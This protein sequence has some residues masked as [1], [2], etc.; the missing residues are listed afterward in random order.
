M[1]TAITALER[2]KD[3]PALPPEF[4]GATPAAAPEKPAPV[5]APATPAAEAAPATEPTLIVN[6]AA[7]GELIGEFINESQEHLANIENGV[8]VLEDDPTNADTLNTIFR[9]FHTFKGGSGFLN[10]LPIQALAHELEFLLDAARQ[11][12]LTLSSP[13][14]DVILEGGDTLKNSSRRSSRSSTARTS[15]SPSACPPRRSSRGSRPSSRT[16]AHPPRPPLLSQR[17]PPRPPLSRP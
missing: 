2:G 9:A 16:P 5:P 15:A 12:K 8:L 1:E 13:I 7:D 11:H 4:S 14:I 10:L 17:R 3:L 6:V